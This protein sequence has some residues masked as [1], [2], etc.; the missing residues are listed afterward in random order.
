MRRG[1]AYTEIWWRNPISRVHLPDPGIDG[2]IIVRGI[3]RKW[4]VWV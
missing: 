1:E 2:R 3:L 4:D